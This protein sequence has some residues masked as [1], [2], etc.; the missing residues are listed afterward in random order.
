[1]LKDL[2]SKMREVLLNTTIDMDS[3]WDLL[4]LEG[5]MIIINQRKEEI[6][7]E[8]RFSRKKLFGKKCFSFI[9]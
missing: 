1:M 6:F 2:I 4:V 5:E 8:I 9:C 7:L 3:V